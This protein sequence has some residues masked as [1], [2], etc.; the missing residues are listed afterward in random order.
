[1]ALLTSFASG[2]LWCQALVL[3]PSRQQAAQGGD[4]IVLPCSACLT[5]GLTCSTRVMSGGSGSKI[6]N[7]SRMSKQGSATRCQVG[8]RLRAGN[9][10]E[11]A[12]GQGVASCRSR[13]CQKWLERRGTVPGGWSTGRSP[14]SPFPR[15]SLS[16]TWRGRNHAR[17]GRR[18]AV[19]ISTPR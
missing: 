12:A 6:Q 3:C 16:I 9:P 18:I 4:G 5:A 11:E 10:V 13:T 17:K 8:E 2:F 7:S 15:P 14:C 1:M 19:G